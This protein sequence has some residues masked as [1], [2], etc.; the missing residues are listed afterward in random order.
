MELDRRAFMGGAV[1][2]TGWLAACQKAD[3]A[4]AAPAPS[5]DVLGPLREYMERHRA[6]WGLP[7]M[8]LAVVTRDGF[9]GVLTS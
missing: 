9:E 3:T 2:A 7:G 4:P 6:A 1:L 5:D 8:T